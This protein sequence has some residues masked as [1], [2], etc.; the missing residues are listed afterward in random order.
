MS[1]LHI[2]VKHRDKCY[3]ATAHSLW[4]EVS[5]ICQAAKAKGARNQPTCRLSGIH[6]PA[7]LSQVLGQ[8][9]VLVSL[10]TGDCPHVT[11]QCQHGW[12][13][14]YQM[15][16]LVLHPLPALPIKQLL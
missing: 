15:V 16:H 5:K 3:R 7:G 1:A 6:L 13:K 8:L 10:T 4:L 14:T 2:S 11:A 9:H 12:H